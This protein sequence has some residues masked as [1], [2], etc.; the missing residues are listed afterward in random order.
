MRVEI[1]LENMSYCH[2]V[3]FP[4]SNSEDEEPIA[5]GIAPATDNNE[6]RFVPMTFAFSPHTLTVV[7]Q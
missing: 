6:D 3:I 5:L 1:E 4:F 7:H 2:C